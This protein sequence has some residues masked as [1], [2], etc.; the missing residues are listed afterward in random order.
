MAW[1]GIDG[2]SSSNMATKTKYADH[3]S[4][5]CV[6]EQLNGF[7]IPEGPFDPQG[8]WRH[9]YGVYTL[10]G[11]G[12]R[13]GTLR[14][15]R[16]KAE[17]AT[18]RLEVELTRRLA[19]GNRQWQR[20]TIRCLDRDW[21]LPV[22]WTFESQL[23]TPAGDVL[24]DTTLKKTARI[25]DGSVRVMGP[26][27]ERRI[28][29]TEPFTV[30]WCLFDYLQ[31]MPSDAEPLS[32]LMLD[33]YDQP[34]PNQWLVY[35]KSTEVLVGVRRAQRRKWE[36]L[37]KGRIRKTYWEPVGGAYHRLHAFEQTGWGIVPWVYW[38]DDVGRLLFAI[39]GLE[40]YILDSFAD[41][42]A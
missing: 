38:R 12:H 5:N 27:R 9:E 6:A 29:V 8:P 41:E 7:Q 42:E 35:R 10:A 23:R 22:S 3:F 19:G 39:S 14:V 16:Y 30:N 36:E 25:D 33:H 2:G 26:G 15:E 17:G 13:S 20:G 28:E 32:F 24:P 31:R 18:Y 1:H 34:K 4:L 21:P 11:Q 40:S 37:E